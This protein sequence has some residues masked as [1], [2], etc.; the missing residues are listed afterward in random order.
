MTLSYR[1][2]CRQHFQ[3]HESSDKEM[4]AFPLRM[5]ASTGAMT[6][7]RWS[8]CNF[9]EGGVRMVCR[10]LLKANDGIISGNQFIQT[11]FVAAQV[12]LSS[13]LLPNFLLLEM[14]G[15]VRTPSHV[16]GLRLI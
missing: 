16:C 8:V 7:S 13:L 6:V 1:L 14:K 12:R 11:K 10:M 2:S 15:S 5:P 9:I 3:G 4:S